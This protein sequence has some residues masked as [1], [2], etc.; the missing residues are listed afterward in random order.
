[1]VPSADAT[2][3]LDLLIA[4]TGLAG[5]GDAPSWKDAGRTQAAPRTSVGKL[6]WRAADPGW[7]QGVPALAEGAGA[8]KGRV[9]RLT[10][11]MLRGCRGGRSIYPGPL[12]RLLSLLPEEQ[13]ALSPPP[14][15]GPR[16]HVAL[17]MGSPCFPRRPWLPVAQP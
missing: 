17:F 1:M 11:G 14:L 5:P 4:G 9:S 16:G 12:P 6:V 15:P 10:P 3:G 2:D 8:G 7:A 13:P